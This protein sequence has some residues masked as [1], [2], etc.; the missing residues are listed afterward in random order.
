MFP[1]RFAR[2]VCLLKMGKELENKVGRSGIIP[3]RLVIGFL[4]A[5]LV[6]IVIFYAISFAK[7]A[8]ENNFASM[9]EPG[10]FKLPF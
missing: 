2:R 1:A 6:L 4:A 3:W 10:N 9:R 7:T 5:I 8:L